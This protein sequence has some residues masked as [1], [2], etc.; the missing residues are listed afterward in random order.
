MRK[1]TNLYRRVST[2]SYK[3][4]PA[5]DNKPGGG[6][7]HN[8]HNSSKCL[9][10]RKTLVK[11]SKDK[12]RAG[13]RLR[14]PCNVRLCSMCLDN[15]SWYL[16]EPHYS[17]CKI[18]SR[19]VCHKCSL[20][21]GVTEKRCC[22]WLCPECSRGRCPVCSREQTHDRREIYTLWPRT[23]STGSVP[24][25][26]LACDVTKMECYKQELRAR[27]LSKVAETRHLT[28]SDIKVLFPETHADLAPCGACGPGTNSALCTSCT[29]VLTVMELLALNPNPLMSS[30]AER[31]IPGRC[32]V[33]HVYNKDT[34]V[35]MLN[36]QRLPL[37]VNA[38]HCKGMLLT[39]PDGTCGPLR[40]LISPQMYDNLNT[41]HSLNPCSCILCL[42][43]NQSSSIAGMLNSESLYL[44][45]H[46]TGPVYYFNIKL[47]P[48]V[49]IPEA[50]IDSYNNYLIQYQG[51]VGC[52]K[53]T[54]YYN[55][56][57]MLAALQI[58]NTG[59]VTI[60]P[61]C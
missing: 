28:P 20:F 58:D 51:T 31:A 4:K 49:G 1:T 35:K 59:R 26:Q 60:L 2:V 30:F 52:F 7:K 43:F 53:P 54:Y 13:V 16:S 42:L 47:T 27:V 34:L 17:S 39:A 36:D 41:Q 21:Y 55:W 25:P 14:C 23:R 29:P 38:Q 50:N 33:R 9:V 24:G 37:C 10:C 61:F 57:D 40:S 18:I 44:E 15:P 5:D 22:L 19:F 48:D 8:K 32:L 45:P 12:C 46:P 11:S 3:K 56:K 6:S